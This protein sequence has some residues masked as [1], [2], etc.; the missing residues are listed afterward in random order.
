MFCDVLVWACGKVIAEK[1]FPTLKNKKEKSEAF[2]EKSGGFLCDFLFWT[3]VAFSFF[4][5]FF[6]AFS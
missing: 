2:N 6:P 4:G 1:K 3:F 5:A